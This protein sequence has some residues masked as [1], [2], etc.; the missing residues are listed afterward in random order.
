MIENEGMDHFYALKG[1]KPLE[2]V[3][4]RAF[5]ALDWTWLI[6]RAVAAESASGSGGVAVLQAGVD[7]VSCVGC[8]WLMEKLFSKEPG[9][10]DCEVHPGQAK[11]RLRWKSGLC[12]IPGFAR[13]LQQFGYTMVPDA[14][15]AGHRAEAS[16]VRLRLGLTSAF[17]MN[18]MAFTLPS[19]LGMG[20]DFF[21]SGLFEQIT[22][23]S[24]T[25]ALLSGGTY[26]M[27]RAI[28]ALRHGVLHMDFPIALGVT[29]AWV[30]SMAG[31]LGGWESLMY[32]DFVAL[33]LTLML[34]GRLLQIAAVERHRNR[35]AGAAALPRQVT[36][37]DGRKLA[38]E[39]INPGLAFD[40]P[41]G[42]VVP[43][44]AVLQTPAADISLEW[45]NGEADTHLWAA[46]RRLPSGAVN[47]SRQPIRLLADEAWEGSLLHRL[48]AVES[49]NG[50]GRRPLLER[51]LRWYVLVVLLVALC[52]ALGWFAAGGGW[53]KSLQVLVSVLVVSCPCAIGLALPLADDLSR[54]LLQRSG[55]FL[56]RDDFWAR[57]TGVRHVLFD[58]TGTLTMERPELLN[59][60]DLDTLDDT[61]RARLRTLVAGSLHPVSRRLLESVGGT[62][63]QNDPTE[64]ED[65]PGQGMRMSDP[66]GICWSLGRPGFGASGNA[67]NPDDYDTVLRR[68]GQLVAGFRFRDML[69]PESRPAVAWLRARGFSID[70]L[71][72]DKKEKVEAIASQLGLPPASAHAN[73]SPREKADWI[74]R[75]DQQKLRTL[76]LGD[77]AN[78]TMAC[79]E[80]A[81]SGTPLMDRSLLEEKADFYFTGRGLGFLPVLFQVGL[82]RQRAVRA[83]F[84]FA[85][86][87]NIGAVAAC[88]A[89][90]MNPLVASVAMPFGS[91]LTMALT[92]S[93]F[94]N[95]LS[96][97][98]FSARHIIVANLWKAGRMAAWTPKS[99]RTWTWSASWPKPTSSAPTCPACAARAA[100]A[101]ASR[102]R[103]AKATASMS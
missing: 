90:L 52:G 95:R 8:L 44:A 34:A 28:G 67:A 48:A 15:T 83:I 77:G 80:A 91:I 76:F 72:G 7:G 49:G 78:D 55:V 86:I 87:Y 50:P 25:L 6:D 29:V 73:M 3:K 23:L 53:V 2:P 79:K 101:A 64:I 70:V 96:T 62:A 41:S 36:D 17:M 61:S 88:L 45:I 30:A 1:D 22:A 26:F 93:C 103:P 75:A 100:A 4:G 54:S 16:E 31:W 81:C 20:K 42:G 99:T 40:V 47:V 85:V 71:S 14:R 12:D 84:L 66:A 11:I 19:Y 32:F 74:L 94:R 37:A 68:D 98:I 102:A 56:R 51:V 21:L 69:R 43:V 18:C 57:L 60:D 10:L 92:V 35:A 38:V 89:G 65:V 59:P 63:L 39:A 82:V 58:K 27:Q 46:G 5:T 24:A 33:F 97:S 9:A 13:K